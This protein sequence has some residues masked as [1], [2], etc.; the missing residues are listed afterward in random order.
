MNAPLN[1]VRDLL[2]LVGE[3]D[4]L[5]RGGDEA[6]LGSVRERLAEH[7]A[8]QIATTLIGAIDGELAVKRGE[9]EPAR[10]GFIRV[11]H[12]PFSLPGALE[13]AQRY[14]IAQGDLQSSMICIGRRHAPLLPAD[15]ST[16]ALYQHLGKDY[17]ELWRPVLAGSSFNPYLLQMLKKRMQDA[18][19]VE[20]GIVGYVLAMAGGRPSSLELKPLGS[21]LDY[22]RAHGGAYH[23]WSSAGVRHLP[24]SIVVGQPR[25]PPYEVAARTV[26]TC[27]LRDAA[28]T[29]GSSSVEAGGRILFDHQPGELE[30][31]ADDFRCDIPVVAVED[32][33]AALVRVDEAAPEIE[34]AISLVGV[35][36]IAFGHWL[37]EFLPRYFALERAG[38]PAHVPVV[39]DTAMPPTHRQALDY[40]T[41]GRRPIIEIPRCSRMKVRRLWVTSNFSYLPLLPYPG[42]EF[43][44]KHLSFDSAAMAR[45]VDSFPLP[46]IERG[47]T[48]EKIYL[49]RRPHLFRQL[50]NGDE[51]EALCRE[52]GFSFVYL[53]DHSFVEQ[54][55]LIRNARQIV[56]P[57]GSA[58][59]LP[60]VYGACGT[61]ILNLH[62][63]FIDETPGLTDLAHARGIEVSVI[64]GTSPGLDPT[65][66][67]RSD[68]SVSL[69]QVR[70]VLD[71]WARA[72]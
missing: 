44:V 7:P 66:R 59:L 41:E 31:L 47:R 56:A 36:S 69:D 48:P 32:G 15:A 28:I 11:L 58:L 60:F 10:E 27:V 24:S 42:Q 61:K 55:S 65:Y 37:I 26:F 34:E 53:E 17:W 13:A 68:F 35:T 39:I 18:H 3:A 57:A 70:E 40:F 45:L 51:V 5:L 9:T 49:A 72:A 16:N 71:S 20:D 63:P 12:A 46:A 54:L 8:S 2:A 1:R 22:A 25:L 67:G 30:D 21:L 4:A 62:P 33:I 19:G 64:L 23:E 50:L 43:T 6:G 52:Q 14:F 38:V 29:A